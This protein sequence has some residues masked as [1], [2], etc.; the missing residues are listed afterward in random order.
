MRFTPLSRRSSMGTRMVLATL[1]CIATASIAFNTELAASWLP[2]P[3]R[4][5]GTWMASLEPVSNLPLVRSLGRRTTV[6][7]G[8]DPVSAP[9]VATDKADYQPYQTVIVTGAG[10]QPGA[11][12]SLNFHQVG[13]SYPD[14]NVVTFADAS[15]TIDT[16]RADTPGDDFVLGLADIGTTYQLTAAGL[17][18]AGVQG[19]ALTT[20]TDNIGVDFKQCANENPVLGACD[21][22]NSIL[23]KEKSRMFEGMSTLQ[24]FILTD[25]PASIAGG[26]YRIQFHMD[27][28]KA[29]SNAHAYDFVTTWDDAIDATDDIAP[30]GLTQPGSLYP[31]ILK[32]FTAGAADVACGPAIPTGGNPSVQD[33]CKALRTAGATAPLNFPNKEVNTADLTSITPI[34]NDSVQ[35]RLDDYQFRYQGAGGHKAIRIYTDQAIDS[36]IFQFN[37]YDAQ[38]NS[39]WSLTFHATST[40]PTAIMLEFGAHIAVGQDP[41]ADANGD[42]GYGLGKGAASISGAPF[43]VSFDLFDNGL[44]DNT[45]D[46]S[47]GSQDNQLSNDILV[48]PVIPTYSTIPKTEDGTGILNAVAPLGTTVHDT[49]IIDSGSAIQLIPAGSTVIF[50]RYNNG[51]CSGTPA[52]Q[53]EVGVT[54]DGGAQ[55]VTAES[56]DFTPSV[57]GQYSYSVDFVSGDET[58]VLSRPG[59]LPADCEPFTIADANIQITPSTATNPTGTTHTLT[60]TVNTLGVNIGAAG[61]TA[62]ASIVSGPGEFVG[63]VDNCSYTGGG[64]TKSCTVVIT[65]NSP[66]TTVVSASSNIPLAGDGSLLRATNTA[67]NTAAG[68]SGNASK[69]WAD[70][71]ISIAASGT[72]QVNSAHTFTVTVQKD[73]GAGGGL[74]AAAGVTVTPSETGVGNVTGGTCTTTT[75]NASGQC[76]IIVNSS[77]TGQSTVGA[78]ATVDVGGGVSV[79]VSTSG[80]GNNS[81]P[82]TKTWVDARITI[83]TSG[84]NAVGAAHTFTVTVQKDAGD[85]NGFVAAAG[86]TVNSTES[87]VGDITGGTCGPTG[88]TDASGQCTVIV[89]SAAP[90]QSTVQASATVGVGGVNIAVA[91]N[92]YGAFNVSN[93]KTW[94]SARIAIA[95]SGTNQVNVAHTF[96][97]T[98]QK[99][100]GAGLVAAAGVTVIPSELGVGTITGG[101]CTTGPT[102][103]A[104]QCTVIVNS[105]ATG[106]S[107]VSA[108]ATVD[109]GGG[110]SAVLSTDGTAGNSGPATKTWVDARITIA[111]SGTNAVGA[112]HTFTVTVQ[113]DAGDGNGFVAAAGVTVNSTESG[114]GSITGGTCGPTGPTNASGQCT[115][116]VNSAAAGQSTVQASATVSVGGV[117][118]AVA[119]NGYGAFN[120]SN[121]KTWVRAQIAIAASGTNQV[122]VAHTFTVTVQKDLGAGLVAAAGVTVT[123]SELGIGNITGGTCTTGPTN[124]SGQCTVIVNSNAVGQSS[125]SASA[126]VDLGGGVSVTV[127]TDGSAGNSGPAVK[128]WVDA[129]ISIGLS[130]T[131]NIGQPHQFTVLVE[132]NAGDA[133]GWVPAAAVAVSSTE[134]GVGNIT[135]GTCGAPAT[136]PTNAAGQCTVIVNSVVPGQSTVNASATVVVG[137]VSIGVATNGYG[138]FQ[139]SN[140]KVW[141]ASYVRLTKNVN[142]APPTASDPVFTFQL[143]TGLSATTAGTL[144]ETKS[145]SAAAGGNVLLFTTALVPG[146]AYQMCE[147]VLPDYTPDFNGFGSFNP[148]GNNPGYICFDFTAPATSG[149]I[150]DITVNNIHESGLALTIGFW[151][152]WASCSNSKGKGQDPTLDRTLQL[153]EP[154]GFLVGDYLSH[155]TN[156]NP[157]VATNC[158]A[159]RNLLDKTAINGGKKMA[160]DPL[161]NMAAQYVAYKLNVQN[162][163]TAC[164]AVGDAAQALLAAHDFNGLTHT[165]LTAEQA[166]YANALNELLDTYNNTNGCGVPP[167]APNPL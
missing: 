58:K 148:G 149:T 67:A 21:W 79:N 128:T 160:S 5:I 78:S 111:T 41:L 127:S 6:E 51:T 140:V 154:T 49:I 75:T 81:G 52:F 102:N 39:Q 40:Q 110:V 36:I 114:V 64:T 66:G 45:D 48:A 151:K 74:V 162:G 131:N 95:A 33:I 108:S 167:T 133:A 11:P 94:V 130:G 65:S 23:N 153:F 80:T 34:L 28:F 126:T 92:G 158:A 44:S 123:P 115:V 1:L 84:T 12:I 122:N 26:N 38:G 150:L 4:Q 69:T 16:S 124:G 120:V 60:I 125:V 157:D 63:G 165:A 7:A 72:N 24:R 59:V 137:G 161:F 147:L 164:A 134:V 166:A 76:T 73:L 17:T 107:S 152:N 86:V 30:P 56:S 57:Y 55:I 106:Q 68:G 118:I 62:T 31:V 61:G 103:A 121:V 77:A 105:S 14:T 32:Q 99:D 42:V 2:Q 90:G 144:L 88:P 50:Y 89:N 91:T 129:R 142:G 141:I 100:L 85:G 46:V 20:F 113:K 54:P 145:T 112:A 13:G 71:R 98:V 82:A 15:G 22:I 116:I 83:G 43:H 146:G 136:G 10:W 70:A 143:W 47:L 9:T 135:G 37:G 35:D 104:G 53:E 29:S 117:N 19:T 25:V 97:V 109:L 155:D 27:A 159:I 138:A 18:A 3:V 101:T 139:I 163:A 119:T 96:T 93:V 132:K 87:G 156:P 8:A